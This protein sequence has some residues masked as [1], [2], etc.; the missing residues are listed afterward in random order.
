[1]AEMIPDRLPSGSSAG[2]KK[3]FDI[4]QNLP[5]SCIVYYEPIIEY[6]YPDFV[7]IC[8]DL[9]VLI[10]E[11]KGWYPKHIVGGDMDYITIKDRGRES[12][13]K[14]PLRQA[15]DYMY[16]LMNAARKHPAYGKLINEVG[17]HKGKFSF[18]FGHMVVLSNITQEQLSN[19]S[20]G[21]LS[22][23]FPG[24]KVVTRDELL[25]QWQAIDEDDLMGALKRFF[26]PWWNFTPLDVGTINALRSIIHPEIV[27]SKKSDKPRSSNT[28]NKDMDSLK[29][30]DTRQE[31]NARNIGD[32]HR[33]IYG[34]AGS[35]KTVLL[36]ARARLL[37]EQ[38]PNSR[39]LVLCYNVSFAAYLRHQLNDLSNVDI[40]NFHAWARKHN[41][42]YSEND[43]LM[44]S[45]LLERLEN[46]YGDAERYDA[47]LIDEAQDFV[48]SW[49][50]CA[51]AAMSDPNEGNLLIVG[52]GSQGLY[53]K[54]KISWKSLGVEARGRTIHTKYDLDKNYRNTK[55]IVDLASIFIENTTEDGSRDLQAADG[56]VAMSVDPEKAI[57]SN[58]QKPILIIRSTRKEE[59]DAIVNSIKLLLDGNQKIGGV[60]GP[61]RPEDI[62]ILYRYAGKNIKPYLKELLNKIKSFSP[63]IWLNEDPE[64]RERIDEPGIKIQTMHSAKGL[65]YKAVFIVFA[66]LMPPFFAETEEELLV[67][68]RLMYVALTRAED[69]AIITSTGS[70]MFVDMIKSSGKA[71]LLLP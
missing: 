17:E 20:I 7:V 59:I 56:I 50:Q 49:F 18:P 2:E 13:E 25:E 9:G 44:G 6:R 10:I 27:I 66:D 11:V 19:H 12:R 38:A 5:D 8:P 16:G 34:V 29:V 54:N 61:I 4:L 48:P 31:N 68:H 65:Q 58:G 21:D 42:P 60:K 45:I 28:V 1:M 70:S 30:L 69:I 24:D 55:E 40:Y 43:E 33:I 63:V 52:D 39:I 22:P 3:V 53:R 57:R 64:N 47:V 46:G 15:R 37:A 41:I 23:L 67:E 35:G 51:L 26:N 32:G 71:E 36:L 14:H 62:G